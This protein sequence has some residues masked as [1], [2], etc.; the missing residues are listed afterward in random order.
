[1]SRVHSGTRAFSR[2]TRR[3]VLIAA[4][5]GVGVS[6]AGVAGLSVA[7]EKGGSN[8]SEPLVLSLRDAKKGTF[9]VFS[10]GSRVTLTDK[11]LAE[12]LLKAAKRG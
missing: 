11:K 4:T 5:V 10:G 12:K 7:G 3:R 9:D 1:M 2:L 6:A 8:D